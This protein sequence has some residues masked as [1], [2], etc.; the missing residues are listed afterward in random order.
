MANGA[1]YQ[2]SGKDNLRGHEKK[3]H[4]T[5]I[6][7]D[8]D[9]GKPAGGTKNMRAYNAAKT[10]AQLKTPTGGANRIPGT[11]SKFSGKGV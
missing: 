4:A 2:R 6:K 7:P 9:S 10:A 8:L 5:Q 11:V 3:M 1:P